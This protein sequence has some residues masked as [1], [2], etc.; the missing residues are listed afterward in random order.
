[1]VTPLGCD[2][3]GLAQSI[4]P[5]VTRKITKLLSSGI[6]DIGEYKVAYNHWTGLADWTGATLRVPHDSLHIVS[7][8]EITSLRTQGFHTKIVS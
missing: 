1:M 6:T 7:T 2:S 5:L 4:H 3:C 8:R